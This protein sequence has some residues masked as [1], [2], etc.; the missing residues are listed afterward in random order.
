MGKTLRRSPRREVGNG[1]S[2]V[3]DQ[4]QRVKPRATQMEE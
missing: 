2:K 4:D 1:C 3:N